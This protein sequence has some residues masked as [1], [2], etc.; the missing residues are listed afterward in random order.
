MNVTIAFRHCA[1]SE[2]KRLSG[3]GFANVEHSDGPGY[4]SYTVRSDGEFIHLVRELRD[5]LVYLELGRLVDGQMPG[6]RDWS[7]RV[8]L[9]QLVPERPDLGSHDESPEGICAAVRDVIDAVVAVAIP[10]FATSA[11]PGSSEGDQTWS[12]RPDSK[13]RC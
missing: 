9:R 2:L 12:G 4:D 3:L 6:W 1:E 10:Y 13:R 11:T 7:N 8:D 5:Q